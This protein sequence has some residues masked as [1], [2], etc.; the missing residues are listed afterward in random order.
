MSNTKSDAKPNLSGVHHGE[1]MRKVRTMLGVKQE[2]LANRLGN[3]WSQKKISTFEDKEEISKDDIKRIAKALGIDSRILS[4]SNN[5]TFHLALHLTTLISTENH[6]L[7]VELT[8]DQI[9]TL[10][11]VM[12]ALTQQLVLFEHLLERQKANQLL[13]KTILTETISSNRM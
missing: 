5:Q 4:E 13:F 1:N 8:L 11:P 6:R 7:A 3:G 2:I 12:D 9:V 10:S